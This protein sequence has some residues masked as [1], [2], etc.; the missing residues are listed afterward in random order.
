M[1][2]DPVKIEKRIRGIGQIIFLFLKNRI[3]RKPDQIKKVS[4]IWIRSIFSTLKNYL[5]KKKKIQ[6]KNPENQKKN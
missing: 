2:N 6:K 5:K 3:D 4:N 1:I